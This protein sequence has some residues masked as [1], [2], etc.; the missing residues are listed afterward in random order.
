MADSAN[1]QNTFGLPHNSYGL[2]DKQDQAV[3]LSEVNLKTDLPRVTERSNLIYFDT[4]DCLGQLSLR[5]AQLAFSYNAAT[6][7]FIEPSEFK[8]ALNNNGNI[9]PSR[10]VDVVSSLNLPGF[11]TLNADDPYVEGNSIQFRLT[12]R[13]KLIKNFEIINAIIPRDII[14]LGNYFP[15][16]IENSIPTTF[17]GTGYQYLSPNQTYSSTWESPILETPE[18]FFDSNVSG[19]ASNKLGGVYFTP[20]RYWRSYTG[21]NCMPNPQTPPP[22]QLW[23]PPQD[24][25]S[26]NPWPF[27]PQP[28]QGQRIPTYVAKNGVTFAGYGLYDLDDFPE[29]Q[30]VQTANGITT[31]IPI[32]KL[33]LKLIVPKGQFINGVAAEELIENSISDDF[34][35]SGIVDN[36]LTQTGYGDY[37]RFLPGPGLA[38]NY[39]P[40]QWR[41]AKS[42]PIDL[43]CTTYDSTTGYLGP[44][45][46]PFPNFRGNVWGPYGRPGD[47]FQNASLQLTIDELY[48]N[49]DLE[50]LEGNSIL[51]PN[52]DPTRETYSF[53]YYIAVLKRINTL[54][55]FN[56]FETASN[57][58]LKNAM[59]VQFEGGFG[60]VSV[61]V[62]I[63]STTRGGVGP[64]NINGLPNTQYDGNVRNFNSQV[65]ITPRADIPSSW[66]ETLS[67]PQKP[68][69][70]SDDT[71]QGW[72]YIWRDIFPYVGQVYVPITAGGVGPM[73]YFSCESDQWM[74]SDSSANLLTTGSS[75]WSCSPVIGQSN[76]Y[77]IPQSTPLNFEYVGNVAYGSVTNIQLMAGGTNYEANQLYS[78]ALYSDLEI[79]SVPFTGYAIEVTSVDSNGTILSLIFVSSINP[80]VDT[81]VCNVVAPL[82]LDIAT[83]GNN[84]ALRKVGLNTFT[85]HTGGS[86]YIL[87]Q[88][89]TTKTQ[90]GNGT[91]LTVNILSIT[92]QGTDILGIIDTYEIA[93]PGSGYQVGDVVLVLQLGSDN[94]ALFRILSVDPTETNVIPEYNIYHYHDPLGV[95]PSAPST[96]PTVDQNFINGADTCTN[97]CPNNCT[98]LQGEYQVCIGQEI[99]DIAT[100]CHDPRPIPDPPCQ[101]KCSFV[102]NDS[103]E[104]EWQQQ[105]DE[106]NITCRPKDNARI[107]QRNSYIDRRVSYNDLGPNNGTLILSLINY[108]SLFIAT[109][110]DTDIII[111]VFQAGRETYTQSLNSKIEGSNFFIPI[112]LNLGTTTGTLEYVEAVAGTLTSSGVYWKKDFYPPLSSLSDLR[113]EFYS[114][115]GTPI[116]LER[117]LGFIPQVNNQVNLL[118]SSIISENIYHGSYSAF[119]PNLPPFTTTTSSTPSGTIISGT[120]NTKSFFNLFNPKLIQYTQRNIALTIRCQTYHGENP[121][122]TH[123]IKRMPESLIQA[124]AQATPQIPIASNLDN[125]DDYIDENDF[126]DLDEY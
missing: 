19:I 23:N 59:R 35:D 65:W 74:K 73:E 39:Q 61:K 68:S 57:P 92:S 63:N 124:Q 93:N 16:F 71:F 17:N 114:Y 115:D 82:T 95:G 72:M 96:F 122:I 46:V 104:V 60:A 56:N 13:L 31:Q 27:Q 119:A 62:G 99:A 1:S 12:N 43:S 113:L 97:D 3:G 107:R 24:F 53:E 69:I 32:R 38:M 40:N 36:P 55:R 54:V 84:C 50:N 87:D 4:R 100:A 94:N 29:T 112:R 106:N 64:L 9:I 121:G 37:Q 26:E 125:Y 41:N 77:C 80:T 86:N 22:Y 120:G 51:W 28:V 102:A 109:V 101:L 81:Y 2:V 88:N 52:F 76:A 30:E 14:P 5:E 89:I 21:P 83:S 58:N 49:G 48:M 85:L 45:P 90:V 42:C 18:D 70:V 116:P 47:R 108:R 91:G 33:I 66:I 11:P 10:L 78:I 67:G 103:P 118:S 117:T 7:G 6:E 75:Q 79:G 111:R 20:L 126:D 8:K 110:P 25:N 44:M 105:I 123:I 98:P 15:G 34:N